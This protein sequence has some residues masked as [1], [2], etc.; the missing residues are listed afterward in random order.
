[1]ERKEIMADL[2]TL[3]DD[4]IAEFKRRLAHSGFTAEMIRVINRSNTGTN[5]MYDALWRQ[6][7]FIRLLSV[8]N[9]KIH[10]AVVSSGVASCAPVSRGPGENR[11]DCHSCHLCGRSW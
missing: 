8:E 9:R 4:E 1:M 2:S 11:H 3:T 10:R 6:P 7:V 5:I